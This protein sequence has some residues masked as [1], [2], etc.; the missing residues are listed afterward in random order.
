M[1]GGW[2]GATGPTSWFPDTADFDV[3]EGL[4]TFLRLRLTSDSATNGNGVRVEDLNMRCLATPPPAGEYQN[5]NGTSMASPHVA[6]A[7]ALL[8]ARN[9][10]MPPSKVRSLLLSTV[11][12]VAGLTG[13]VVTAG[14]LN[15][16]NAM[17]LIDLTKPN[18]SIKS[19]PKAKTKSKTATFKF[20]SSEPGSTFKCKLD[21][22]AWTACKSAKTYKKLKLGKHTFQVA[23]VDSFGNTDATPSKKTWK[24]IK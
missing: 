22:G 19:A 23:A 8:L 21:K 5:L 12:P 13:K 10:A 24:V 14:R 20:T 2:S 1:T 6:G 7:A 3:F 4:N 17:P 16:A 18:T 11:D 15:V 9:P